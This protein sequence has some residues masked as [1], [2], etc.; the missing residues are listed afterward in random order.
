MCGNRQVSSLESVTLLRPRRKK[1]AAS[2]LAS[3]SVIGAHSSRRSAARDRSHGQRSASRPETLIC[4]HLPMV[5]FAT[6][7]DE[8]R[9]REF[10]MSSSQDGKRRAKAEDGLS[11]IALHHSAALQMLGGAKCRTCSKAY[12]VGG[13]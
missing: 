11:C 10:I 2:L 12:R 1:T 6:A 9:A 7:G 3:A 13:L 8:L 4:E 5:G